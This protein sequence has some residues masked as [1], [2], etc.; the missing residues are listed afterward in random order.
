M[1]V[2]V[3]VC[4][5]G[6][7]RGVALVPRAYHGGRKGGEGKVTFVGVRLKPPNIYNIPI[8]PLGGKRYKRGTSATGVIG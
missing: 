1:E 7:G 5:E 2:V 6:G 3:C 4:V 8:Q